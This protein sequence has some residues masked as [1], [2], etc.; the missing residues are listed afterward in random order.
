MTVSWVP[1]PLSPPDASSKT[2]EGYLLQAST[3]ADFSGTL[4]SSGTPNAA[5]STL[6]VTGLAGYTTYYL[7]V[8][9]LNW[10]GVP[11]YAAAAATRTTTGAAP[12]NPVVTA[13]Y[14]SSV[15]VAWGQVGAQDGYVVEASTASDFT[16]VRTSVTPNGL[17]GALSVLSLDPN[18]TYYLRVGSIV[19]GATN[20]TL[21]APASTT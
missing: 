15:S 9:A 7:R 4:F 14:L 18:T 3:A 5:L 20:Y 16:A 10:N 6:S 12:L 21:T 19:N 2:A 11:T 17:A 1:S 13:V 8:G